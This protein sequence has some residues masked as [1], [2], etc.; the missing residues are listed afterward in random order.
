MTKLLIPLSLLVLLGGCV[1]GRPYPGYYG[2]GYY[3]G[4]RYGGGYGYHH[5]HH[6]G[7]GHYGW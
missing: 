2:G 6:H 1:V 4:P 3:G 5:V 7:C